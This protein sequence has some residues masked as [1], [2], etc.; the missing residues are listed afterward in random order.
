MLKLEGAAH[1]ERTYC[2]FNQL[3][4]TSRLEITVASLSSSKI[5]GDVPNRLK[6]DQITNLSD[7]AAMVIVPG[8]PCI[9]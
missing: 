9:S 4:S 5:G 7:R 3:Y 6:V 2:V 8:G 1:N